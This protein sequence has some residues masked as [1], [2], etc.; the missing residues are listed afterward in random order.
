MEVPRLR[1]QREASW[2]TK[3][4]DFSLLGDCLLWAF[5]IYGSIPYFCAAYFQPHQKLS[6]KFDNE[7]VGLLFG[8]YFQKLIWSPWSR[9]ARFFLV[10]HTKKTG[11]NIPKDH[12]L[13]QMAIKYNKWP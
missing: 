6:I 3:L 12:K 11:K 5:L 4:G 2:V 13:Y 9:V 8:Q 1:S 7:C 10:Q